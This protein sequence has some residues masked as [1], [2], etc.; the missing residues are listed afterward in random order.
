VLPAQAETFESLYK[1]RSGQ[2]CPV[3]K[4]SLYF[5]ITYGENLDMPSYRCISGNTTL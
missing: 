5:V 1:L 3:T 2:Q 4:D